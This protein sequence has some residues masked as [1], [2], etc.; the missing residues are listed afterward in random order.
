MENKLELGYFDERW[1]LPS[2]L[3]C[4]KLAFASFPWYESLSDKELQKRWHTYRT[5]PGFRCLV[6]R[7]HTR[8]IEG[9]KNPPVELG[10]F[11]MLK[12]LFQ[13]SS[14]G[15]LCGFNSLL[16]GFPRHFQGGSVG[17]LGSL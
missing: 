5:R 6:A 12:I 10:D 13:S 9:I 7:E 15:F 14:F 16:V 8:T 2:L 11:C 1:D 3:E 17:V 4:Y